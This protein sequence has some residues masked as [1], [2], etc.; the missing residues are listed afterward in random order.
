M[1]S[2]LSIFTSA[3][4]PIAT[5]A[6]VGFVLGRT[7]DVDPGPMNT[8]VVYVLAPALVFHSLAVTDLSGSALVRVAGGLT[9]FTLAMIAIGEVVGRLVGVDEPFRSA[10]VL[11]A[12]FP[13]SGN[14][15][16]PLS[17]FAF[18]ATGRSTAVL[19]MSVQGVLIYTV[20]IYIASRSG[21]KRGMAGVRR[22][23]TVPLVYAVVAA[24]A[25]RWLGVVPPADGTLMQTTKLVGDSAIPVMLL[26]LGVQLARTDY[27][28]ALSKVGTASALKMAVAP[29]VGAA[30]A[31]ALGFDDPTVA[32]VFVLECAMP[33]AVTPMILLLEFGDDRGS[34]LTVGEYVSTAVMV[35]TLLSVP[36]LTAVIAVL[37]SG[38]V[39]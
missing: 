18:G 12:A 9:A 16:V 32:R 20:G 27:G 33:A 21:G 14:Y 31:L 38:L 19:Y 23:F 8:A 2:L 5:I 28:A 25:A 29:V 15:G 39:V 7:Q 22:V 30:I 26:I 34:G 35:T 13:N 36:I 4:L 6:A 1:S 3:I 24:L 37:E 10:L 17:S 11:V